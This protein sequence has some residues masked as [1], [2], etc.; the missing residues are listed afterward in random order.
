MTSKILVTTESHSVSDQK[1]IE[2]KRN[3]LPISI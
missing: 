3:G 2:I 1:K